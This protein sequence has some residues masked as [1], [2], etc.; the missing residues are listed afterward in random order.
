MV[1]SY[2]SLDSIQILRKRP[3]H[4]IGSIKNPN[5]LAT[6]IVD[7]MLD[8][9]TNGFANNVSIIFQ[10]DGSLFIIDNGRGLQV[11]NMELFDGSVADSVEVLATILYTGSKFDTDDYT[12]LI[13]MHGVGLVATNAL[14]DWLIIKTFDRTTKI[15]YEYQFVDSK[16]LAKTQ[17]D[18]KFDG[19][20]TT[21]VGF[22]PSK[23][24][25]ETIEFDKD[26]LIQRILLAQSK[27]SHCDFHINGIKLP[28]QSFYDFKKTMLLL[29]ENDI[30]YDFTYDYDGTDNKFTTS[31]IHVSINYVNNPE[32]LCFGDV[33]LK[34]CE[35]TFLTSF[36]TL[37]KN[38]ILEKLNI[39]NIK[40]F[41]QNALFN[42]LRLYISLSI[43]EPTYGG[44]AKDKMTLR[45]NQLID[46]LAGY[47]DWFLKESNAL[48]IIQS[49]IINKPTKKT[50]KNSSRLSTENPT[51]D[52]TT[53]PG[54]ILYLIEGESAKSTFRKI[55][56]ANT[57]G[58]YMFG[59]KIINVFK[60]GIEKLLNND[61]WKYFKQTIGETLDTRRYEEICIVAD[62]DVDGYN[63]ID[64]AIFHI[65]KHCSEF[66]KNKKC[67]IILPPLYGA[68]KNNKF[69]PIYDVNKVD[70]FR[71]Q[72]YE[73]QRC[74]GLGEFDTPQ[75]HE[76]IKVSPLKYVLTWP[77]NDSE[78]GTIIKLLTDTK[79]KKYLLTEKQCNIN[80]MFN[81]ILS[82]EK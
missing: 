32:T 24:Y 41:N 51:I 28:K 21:L 14:S 26:Q 11:Y 2:K 20:W 53:I 36:L 7:N 63:I 15:L 4:F 79:I 54:K 34:I 49:N 31:K 81:K 48:N 3:D 42:G 37:L 72:N 25:F 17:L 52:S 75:L 78:V 73:I 13:G 16:L 47:I 10:D 65:I 29:E 23:N 56:D 69:I 38:K 30:L 40:N 44:Q 18:D 71:K 64:L 61:E 5:H 22:K 19:Q 35:G 68:V 67:N 9:V 60:H 43:P 12:N 1:N 59:G 80:T 46:P 27:N 45:V 76:I 39:I 66:I 70:S 77:D 8:E 55:I 62:P 50:K 74:K 58:I 6:E 33:N 57:E 82:K